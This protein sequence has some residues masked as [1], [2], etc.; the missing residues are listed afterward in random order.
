MGDI[1]TYLET[2]STEASFN[3]AFEEYVLEHRI[4]GDILILWQNDN[5]IIVGRNQNTEEEINH[6]YIDANHVKVVRRSTGGGAVYHDLGNLNYSFITDVGDPEK[7]TMDR[8][9][10]PIVD[11][12]KKMGIHAETS[13]RNDIVIEG[14]KVS[15]TAQRIEGNR[16]LHHGTLLF[17]SDSSKIAGA[18]HVDPQKFRSKSTKSVQ[19]RVGNI[20]DYLYSDMTIKEFWT[21][22]K[23]L[24]AGNGFIADTLTFEELA[25]IQK[26]KQLKY[27]TWEWNYGRNPAFEIHKKRYWDGGCL[28]VYANVKEG[29]T[30][31][32]CFYG[33]FLGLRPMDEV[34]QLIIGKPFMRDAY[35]KVLDGLRISDYFGSITK[36]EILITIFE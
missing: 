16:I 6:S 8:F 13:G 34:V 31:G 5:A 20:S 29:F 27:D 7:L 3:L 25:Q 22:L 36:K 26:I 4:V 21:Q 28:E 32:I 10:T 23:G 14:R 24:L 1:V 9:T 2:Q 33:D 11:A 17:S 15:G 30:G 12:L 19:A 18:L 35:I